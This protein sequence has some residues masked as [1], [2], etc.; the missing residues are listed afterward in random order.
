MKRIPFFVYLLMLLVPTALFADSVSKQETG[1]ST[2]LNG[3]SSNYQFNAEVGAPGA[4]RST[5]TNYMYDHG[6]Y[7][8]GD[9]GLLALIGWAKPQGRVGGP[10]IKV[11]AFLYLPSFPI[12]HLEL[13]G[14]YGREAVMAWDGPLGSHRWHRAI[15][16]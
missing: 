9:S 1:A 2:I 12:P 14:N 13:R 5:S 16:S 15:G 10:E 8:G 6:M 4:G 11:D 3:A 7:W